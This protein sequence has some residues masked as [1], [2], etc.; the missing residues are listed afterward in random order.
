MAP[1]VVPEEVVLFIESVVP[2]IV[3][4]VSVVVPGVPIEPAVPM[5]EP[6]VPD[7]VPEVVPDPVAALTFAPAARATVRNAPTH[8]CL[9]F[10]FIKSSL[11]DVR[12]A[13]Y[14]FNQKPT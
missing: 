3:P 12:K 10:L 6:V 5:P 7:A 11:D 1:E 4:V 9:K 13:M 14:M 8:T 2:L